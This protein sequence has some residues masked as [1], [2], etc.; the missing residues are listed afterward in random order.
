[1]KLEFINIKAN[2]VDGVA[3]FTEELNKLFKKREEEKM[4]EVMGIHITSTDTSIPFLQYRLVLS[5]KKAIILGEYVT[6]SLNPMQR[7]PY[8]FIKPKNNFT[9]YEHNS[10][11]VE[12]NKRTPAD[13]ITPKTKVTLA[14]RPI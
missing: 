3:D 12:V 4:M 1:M 9:I 2:L 13:Y 7:E 8:S 11:S 14:L 6:P 10:F 5:H